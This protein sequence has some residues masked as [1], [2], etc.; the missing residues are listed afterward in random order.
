MMSALYMRGL[1]QGDTQMTCS[2]L[3][4]AALFFFLS[5][6]KPIGSISD[7]RP[8]SSVFSSAVS[9]SII[10]QFA[11]HLTTMFLTMRLCE[12][13][14]SDDDFSLSPDGKF[15]PNLINS[16]M[17]ILST[18]MLVNN[19]WV[20]YRGPPYMEE[21]SSII[22]FWRLLQGVYVV[23]LIVVGGQFEPI[24]DLLQLV[25]FPNQDFQ[26]KFLAILAANAGITYF[27]EKACRKLE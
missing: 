5:Q 10:G 17:F 16:A 15:S 13:H 25:Q 24:N 2:G 6:A 22:Y 12:L 23:I 9:Y 14:T 21:L 27:I 26:V 19:F 11:V 20:N 18:Q 8:P 7:T 4:L 3:V 1:K